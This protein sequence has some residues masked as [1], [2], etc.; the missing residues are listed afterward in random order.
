MTYRVDNH[1]PQNVYRD[2]AY[3]GVMF[4]AEDATLVVEAL[5]GTEPV[6]KAA[7]G[8]TNPH[9]P[10]DFGE[11]FDEECAGIPGPTAQGPLAYDTTKA[12][13]KHLRILGYS[14]GSV[15]WDGALAAARAYADRP[16]V[17]YSEP[18]V[19]DWE[20]CT[21]PTPYR[22][23]TKPDPACDGSGRTC[24]RHGAVM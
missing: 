23:S 1:Q 20:S 19:E 6:D 22:S 2:D 12:I 10:H 17:A 4:T 3:I 8:R 5:N 18:S 11:M 14:Y 7:C 24:P 21:C 13:E 9:M 15:E 16:Q